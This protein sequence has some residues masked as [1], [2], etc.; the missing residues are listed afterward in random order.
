[1]QEFVHNLRHGEPI[2]EMGMHMSAVVRQFLVD[3]G[4]A[5]SRAI[6]G[7][8]ELWNR[9]GNQNL[10]VEAWTRQGWLVDDIMVINCMVPEVKVYFTGDLRTQKLGAA[11]F[12]ML[13]F[14]QFSGY[15]PRT[16]MTNEKDIEVFI[17]CYKKVF[18]ST[19]PVLLPK[20]S[21]R[22]ATQTLRRRRLHN[23]RT[24]TDEEMQL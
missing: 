14:M 21:N 4:D 11:F 18:S 2:P 8:M 17:H 1:M 22:P 16:P 3:A 15:D 24:S 19:V 20:E 6:P 9:Y 7:L 10:M 12:R 5:Y 23:R 13:Y